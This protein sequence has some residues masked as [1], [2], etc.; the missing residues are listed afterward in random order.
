MGY[1]APRLPGKR[2]LI[3]S[4][5]QAA[6]LLIVVGV[7]AALIAALANP[8]GIGSSGFGWHQGLLLGI[9]IVLALTGIVLGWAARRT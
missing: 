4:A 6:L 2:G 5:R 7:I 3:M 1:V 9:G 8:L